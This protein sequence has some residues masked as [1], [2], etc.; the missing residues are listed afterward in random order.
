MT[1]NVTSVK[2]SA[3]A[4]DSK[5]KV[6]GVGE[7]KLNVGSNTIAIT[8][9]AESGARNVVTVTVTRKDGYYLEDIDQVLAGDGDADI[10]LKDS[11]IISKENVE[12]IKNSGKSVSFIVNGETTKYGWVIDGAK[13]SE[14]KDFDA[15]IT[16]TDLEDNKDASKLSNYAD[17]LLV[18]FNQSGTFIGGTTVRI[19]VGDK[20]S[21]G[22]LINIYYYEKDGERLESVTSAVAV[23]DGYLVFIPQLFPN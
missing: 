1:N 21:D 23:K 4:E 8:I 7:H 14:V 16:V 6:S 19:Y 22:D 13:I 20:Y 2:I 3:S 9:T 10:I 11:T 18:T 12:K 15:G 5:A 17:G